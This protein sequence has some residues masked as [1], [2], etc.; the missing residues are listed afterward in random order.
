MSHTKRLP[1][2]PRSAYWTTIRAIAQEMHSD[3]C[4]GVPDFYIDACYEHDY[5]YRYAE[6]LYGFPVT[7]VEADA[8][9]RQVIQA[10]S[11]FGRFSPMAAWRWVGLRLF[12]ERAWE[13]HRAKETR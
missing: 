7:R 13:T 3:G 10:R 4:S 6:T 11:R 8:R 1:L 9:F 5:H 12:G 2:D